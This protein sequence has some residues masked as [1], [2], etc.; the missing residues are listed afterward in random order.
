M[1]SDDEDAEEENNNDWGT[2]PVGW[3]PSS[4]GCC[5]F[6]KHTLQ[7]ISSIAFSYALGLLSFYVLPF[8]NA[9]LSSFFILFIHVIFLALVCPGREEEMETKHQ[10]QE[11]CFAEGG[12]LCFP[13]RCHQHV[14]ADSGGR[15]QRALTEYY[16]ECWASGD[17]DGSWWWL[18]PYILLAPSGALIAIP[19]YYWPTTTTSST[20]LFR[21]SMS[22]FI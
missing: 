17:V 1:K 3:G 16:G 20:N 11:M 21:F 5:G 12:S 10:H 14:K 15:Q 7:P 22:A 19:T 2:E 13:G 8:I 4:G 9:C 6:A 18:F